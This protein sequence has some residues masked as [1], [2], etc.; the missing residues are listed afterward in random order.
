MVEREWIYRKNVRLQTRL[1][2][3]RLRQSACIEN[4]SFRA[5]RKLDKGSILALGACSWIKE[6]RNILI[7]GPTGA[8]KS[9]LACALGHKAC[10]ADYRVRYYRLS[11]LFEE[12]ATS[13]EEGRYVRF[14]ESLARFHVLILDDW[15]LESMTHKQRMA[16]L[17]ILE[18]R[19]SQK[20]TIITSQIPVDS[21]HEVVGDATLADAILDRVV[22]NSYKIDLQGESMRK[23]EGKKSR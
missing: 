7:T 3:A 15:G 2:A 13:K 21:W 12:A 17:E 14:L 11:R 10:M 18:D 6:A 20:S 1:R 4:L 5:D 9:Y 19:Y 8:G 22:H 16:L 23:L